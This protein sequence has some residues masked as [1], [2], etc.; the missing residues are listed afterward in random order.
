MSG[1]QLF[2]KFFFTAHIFIKPAGIPRV[3]MHDPSILPASVWLIINIGSSKKQLTF[4]AGIL[5]EPCRSLQ[6]YGLKNLINSCEF[7]R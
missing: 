3:T 7:P 5:A 4:P 2:F 1:R 6:Y